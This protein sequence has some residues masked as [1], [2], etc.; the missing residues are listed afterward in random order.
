MYATTTVP[1]QVVPDEVKVRAFVGQ[2]SCHLGDLYLAF[3]PNEADRLAAAL[4]QGAA[5]ARAEA[6][7]KEVQA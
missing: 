3:T 4:V 1:H 2:V 5:Q 6:K 7:V